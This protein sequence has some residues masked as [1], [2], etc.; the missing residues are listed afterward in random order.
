MDARRWSLSPSSF[1]LLGQ[2][3]LLVAVWAVLCALHWDNDG[4]WFQGD[5][6]RHALNGLFWYDYLKSMSLDPKGYALSYYARY[7]AIHPTAYPP[8]FYVLEGAL[9]GLVK[10]SPFLAKGLV[11]G[12]ALLA[13]LY[14]TVWL[15][16]WFMPAAGWAGPLLLLLPGIVCW[17]HAVMLNVPALGLGLAALYHGR[18]WLEEPEPGPRSHLIAAAALCVLAT[19]TYTTAAV[20][21]FILIAWMLVLR[22]WRR[23][24]QPSTLLVG[25]V[26]ALAVLPWAYVVL[27][28]APSHVEWVKPKMSRLG[29]S[30]A[31]LYYLEKMP[32]LASPPILV[33]A[34][35]GAVAGL[36]SRRW[37]GEAILLTLWVAVC[38]GFFSQ[39][40][41]K[42]I[43]YL[44]LICPA[45]LC[46]A[47]LGVVQVG[48][49]LL[50]RPVVATAL[51]S[52]FVAQGW[53]AMRVPVPGVEGFQQVVNYVEQ[54]APDEPVFYDGYHH[55]VFVFYLRAG[56]PDCRRR[57]VLGS[58]LLY[59]TA[60]G[61][62]HHYQE[63][64]F[65]SADVVETL[66]A[67]S[68]CRWLVI[69]NG[70]P[71][72]DLPAQRR[73][74]DALHGPE[75][76]LVRRFPVRARKVSHIDVYRLLA[77][78]ESP[79]EIEMPFPALGKQVRYTVRPIERFRSEP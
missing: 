69:E 29:N 18:R 14:T 42:E 49:R 4:L 6:P 41:A 68:G 54:V 70:D 35:V 45:L 38:Y 63:F 44:L 11:L 36:A 61:S 16:R 5:A 66:S 78:V 51:T 28:Y 9:L 8:V 74:R 31:W 13:G 22:R 21:V 15:R 58:K 26:S 76:E 62:R 40:A 25:L 37:R 10:P 60:V 75:F 34:A 79:A 64:V 1:E 55:G 56:D 71:A 50:S 67:R 57:V 7:P 65:S 33:L 27:K 19:L 20:V 3:A 73:L 23:L 32:E 17:S 43:R 52:C 72:D 53:L 2:L 39:I 77:S 12:F 47:V 46:L 24:L 48:G 59:A 30:S